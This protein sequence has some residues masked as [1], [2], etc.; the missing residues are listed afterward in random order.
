MTVYNIKN[1][2]FREVTLRPSRD[3]PGEGLLGVIIKFDSY[4]GAEE[5]LCHVLEVE[6][7]SPAELAGLEADNDYLLGS[8]EVAFKDTELLSNVLRANI[9]RPIE[10][11][12]YNCVSDEVRIVVL[13]PNADWGGQGILGANVAHG[14]LHVLPS[15]CCHT[16]GK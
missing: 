6:S 10:V 12:V 16:I 5:S 3:W 1:K 4:Q 15:S 11:Y 7:N 8:A 13:M 2:S 14:I 9:D